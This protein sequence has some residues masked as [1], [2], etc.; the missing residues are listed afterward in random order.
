MAHAHTHLSG[1]SLQAAA[2]A[3]LTEAGEQWT[4][5]RTRVFE[6]LSRF[7]RPA[8][9]Y[10]IA[11]AVSAD[12]GRRMPANSVYRILDLFVEANLAHRVESS[13]GYVVNAHPACRHDCM[14]LICEACGGMTHIDDDPLT[15]SLRAAAQRSG[16][17][18]SRSVI[19][20]HGRCTDCT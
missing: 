8:S 5:T 19:E 7:D 16:F 17:A 15:R 1:A 10:E 18:P 14:F 12:I 11:E 2:Q 13:N 3:V 9:A 6:T 4:D 20:I